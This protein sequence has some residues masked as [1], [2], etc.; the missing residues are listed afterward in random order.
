M[1]KIRI[2]TERG[3]IYRYRI[4][5]LTGEHKEIL[6]QT[7]DCVRFFKPIKHPNGTWIKED[8][9]YPYE[10]VT[11]RPDMK[12]FTIS[13]K[14]DEEIDAFEQKYGVEWNDQYE[15][16][17]RIGKHIQAE[18]ICNPD[19]SVELKRTDGF[20]RTYSSITECLH[21]WSG[22]F[23][24]NFDRK[25]YLENARNMLYSIS[26]TIEEQTKE[27]DHM[28]SSIEEAKEIVFRKIKQYCETNDIFNKDVFV[29]YVVHTDLGYEDGEEGWWHVNYKG[30]LYCLQ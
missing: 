12:Q 6:G 24:S 5:Y 1:K 20:H 2:N 21:S 23:A 29:S 10:Y 16:L 9:L 25:Y 14:T 3:S 17:F 26:I 22:L 11:Y 27:Y 28:F 7:A 19:K 8:Y 13:V 4:G 30:R 15:A 18:V